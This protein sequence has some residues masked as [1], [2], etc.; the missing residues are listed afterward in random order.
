MKRYKVEQDGVLEVGQVMY[1]K[2]YVLTLDR[3][4]CKGCEL[5][6]LACPRECIKL[7]PSE[8]IDGKAVAPT[9]D[10]DENVC[11]FHGICAVVCPFNA[12]RIAVNGD[13][14][15]NAVKMGV[16][17]TLTRDIS[18]DSSLCEEDCFTCEEVCPLGI[19]AVSKDEDKT[20]VDVKTELCAGCRICWDECPSQCIEVTKF[21]EGSITINSEHC[22]EGC[23]RCLDVCPL[24]AIYIDDEDRV[25]AKNN[26]CVY[27]G[28]CKMVCPNDEALTLIRTSIQHSPISSGAWNK[29]LE[30]LTSTAGL[31]RELAAER[32]GKL[33]TTVKSLERTE[34]NE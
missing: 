24:D 32:I 11:D 12:I 8:D 33:R 34:E 25:Y 20:N 9:V 31:M 7:V 5:C 28:A 3:E 22:P 23:T 2:K 30:K 14:T 16:F 26:Y 29:G 6:M 19:I 1:T 18:I 4:L 17:P 27:C 13:E 15:I 21:I 10:I